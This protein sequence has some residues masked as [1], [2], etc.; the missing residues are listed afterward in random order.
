MN[1][2]D[3]LG[4]SH[5]ENLYYPDSDE[6]KN[7]HS[8]H[9]LFVGI[10]PQAIYMADNKPFV[11]FC[12]SHEKSISPILIKKIWNAQIP[13]LIVSFENRIEVY[14]GRSIDYNRDLVLLETL[15]DETVDENSP[16][17][18]W[19][20]SDAAFWSNY[21][22]KLS[23]P[24]LDVVM[25]DNIRE[26]T[27]SLKKTQCAPFAVK[28]VL[29]LIFIRY[30]IDRGVDLAY[31]NLTGDVASS[32][33]EF[34]TF[35]RDKTKLYNLFL[36]LK[37]RFNGNLFELYEDE[38]GSEA[39]L[40]DSSALDILYK[41]M[42]GDLILSSGQKSL[43]QLYD[44][45]IISVELISNI[46]ERFLGDE[47]QKHDKAFYTPPYLVD[48]LLAQTVAPFLRENHTC[49]ILDP[50]CGSGIFLV[51]SARKLIE[52]AVVEKGNGALTDQ[53]LVDTVTECLWGIDKNPEAIDVAIFSIYLTILD[54]KDPKTLKDFKLPFLRD[55]NFFAEDFFSEQIEIYLRGKE[56]D[57]IIGNSPWGSVSGLHEQY[58]QDRNL[59]IQEREI[60]RSFVLRAKDFS[61][62]NTC[63]CLIVTSKLF[64]NK[65]SP[66]VCFREWLLVN[67]K[68]E[69][70]IE[71]AAVR[72][73]IFSKVRGP[74]GVIIYR[75]SDD[76][77]ANEV[78]ELCHLTLKPN[79]FFK[80]FNIIVIEK[81]NHKYVPQSLLIEND[82]AWKTLV[83]GHA[84]D[85]HLIKGLIEK[86]PTV[87]E[88]L[89]QFSLKH[90]T[91]ICL[92]DGKN[93]AS[94]LCGYWL[95]D[96][97]KGIRPFEVTL[98]YGK[99]FTKKRIYRAKKDKMDLFQAP[100]VLIKKGFDTKTYKFRAAY[101]DES[102]LYTDAITGICGRENDKNILLSL[103]GLIN[104]SLYAYLN[105]MVGSSSG[106]EREQCFPAEI[107]KCP[108]II[109]DEIADLAGDIQSA[110]AR[111]RDFFNCENK[112]SELKQT[113]DALILD[114]FGLNEVPF[115]DY[116]LTVQIPLIAKNK[117]VWDVVTSSQLHEYAQVLTDYFSEIFSHRDKY[118]SVNIFNNIAHHYCAVELIFQDT[119]PSA[120]FTEYDGSQ[121]AHMDIMS[122]FAINK[123]NDLFYQMRDII[124]FSKT[125]FYILKTNEYRNWHPAMARLDLSDIL[126]SIFAGNEEGEP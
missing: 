28:A 93:D 126:D 37:E 64:Y 97:K 116:T 103:A 84:H 1:A 14:N 85:F 75:F 27:Y 66:A 58:C 123:V 119:A 107:F 36:Y 87:S 34:L 57:F 11:V 74:A 111:E 76:R 95:I 101:S 2:L 82:W 100:Y 40:L 88:T 13:L 78:N 26:A 44:F 29:R 25:L 79:I 60:S 51:E 59:P 121:N 90:G 62:E 96:A 5:S 35:L 61:N 9:K 4:Y 3:N 46:Y 22:E 49:K 112:S 21:Y 65:K 117:M 81:N 23:S 39:D 106:I 110:I 94:H 31:E 30:L 53:E 15:F 52:R 77:K 89:E 47:R 48:Y 125:S 113:L 38:H 102:F 73:L 6:T 72:E 50:A 33:A 114:K 69:R 86:Y 108:V 12:E 83:F 120:A 55:Q 67:A 99:T 8:W 20:I 56:F 45:N 122:K 24:K 42:S 105:L 10:Q 16:F 70:Y 19:K 98:E 17:S 92:A 7:N 80:L 124:S 18:Y 68:I 54:Y 104:S 71:L 63:C 109:D 118:V 41:L 43:F 115:I 32:Q 91:G